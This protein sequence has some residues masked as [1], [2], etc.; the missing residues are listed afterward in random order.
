MMFRNALIFLGVVVPVAGFSQISVFDASYRLEAVARSGTANN[1]QTIPVN[2]MGPVP[3][4]FNQANANASQ[5]TSMVHSWSSV[6]WNCTPTD[7]DAE[8][9]ACWDSMDLGAGNSGH[10]LS[11]LSLSLNLA[12]LSFVTTAAVFDAP[13]SWI[14]IDQ[15]NGSS[16]VLLVNSSQVV[17]YSALWNPGNYRFRSERLYNPVGNS[18]GCVP[19]SF[20]LHAEP[21]PEPATIFVLSAGGALLLRR[22]RAG[23]VEPR[24]K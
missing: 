17:N 22:R 3:T 5:F 4:Y 8:L 2:N 12:T 18:T 23:R 7:L 6:S 11:R 14:E 19:Y 10:M 9:I 13:N 16:W 15:W 24:T 1:S 20:H 21:V